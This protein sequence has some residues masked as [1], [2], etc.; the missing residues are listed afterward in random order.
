MV[1]LRD[2]IQQ[3]L[4]GIDP[5]ILARGEDYYRSGKV[6]H[7]ERDGGY[8]TAEVSGSE[9]E[10]YLVELDLTED[11]EVEGWSCDCPYDWGDVCKHTA[12]VL[13]A[14]QA[15]DGL[16]RKEKPE[17]VSVQ[18]LVAQA[19]REQLEALILEHC[20]ENKR[21]KGRVLSALEST[22]EHELASIKELVKA[23]IR[24]NTYRG[25]INEQ[26][27]DAICA[28]LDDA[29]DKARR[30]VERGQHEQALDIVRFVL[31][32]GLELAEDA[33]SS[34][35]SLSCTIDAA[36]E[37]V[38]LMANALAE[39][40]AGRAECVAK[41]LDTVEDAAFDGWDFWRNDLLKRAAI[42]ADGQNEGKFYA[43]LDRLSD[44][45]WEK[46]ED[47]P[48]YAQ[49]DKIIR[50]HIVRSARGEAAARAYLEQNLDVDELRLMLV[51]EDME[52]KNYAN[53]ERL[54]RERAEKEQTQ[55][56][57]QPSQWEYL[58]YEI[59]Q[60]WGQR[61]RQV[62]QARRLA[63]LGGEGY[64]QVAKD[65]M[66]EAG[67]WTEEYPKFLAELKVARSAY[68]YMEILDQE[69]EKA[70]LMEQVRLY[71]NRVFRYGGALFSEYGG[72]ICVLCA[73]RIRRD[74]ENAGNRN[75]YQQVC[76]L[77][78]MLAEFGGMKEAKHLIAELQRGYPRR[79][80]MQDELEQLAQKI[81]RKP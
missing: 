27:C 22:G 76:K 13:L 72:E 64:Y 31:L 66:L 20:R 81:G 49:Q 58:L 48:R 29:L 32:T 8:V 73:E 6:E 23:S 59:Y 17:K 18:R 67:R 10:P 45:R 40:G 41:L 53:A 25:Y 70:L 57:Y 68:E 33:D 75:A 51:R 78:Q 36:I 80:A 4:D 39:S 43:V 37:T 5:K 7:I 62:E 69:G 3:F 46:F 77:I 34:S 9:D 28:D 71:P 44:R 35:G 24:G 47:N 56:W 1:S 63:L 2:G 60:K 74:A 21:F 79:R 15:G 11:G 30:R 19:S 42:L 38:E 65:L 26:G 16:P 55:R 54:C 52:K 12:A 14:L 61:E 50:W